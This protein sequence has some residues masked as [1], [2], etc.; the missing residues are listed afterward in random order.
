[1]ILI[2]RLSLCDPNHLSDELMFFFE[3]EHLLERQILEP[4]C[5][6][7]PPVRRL[8]VVGSDLSQCDPGPDALDR[9]HSRDRGRGGHHPIMA[10]VDRPDSQTI[11]TSPNVRNRSC[12]RAVCIEPNRALGREVTSAD[13]ILVGVGEIVDAEFAKS[14]GPGTVPLSPVRV[15]VGIAVN[16]V[17]AV[18]AD[19][20]DACKV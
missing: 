19:L 8:G 6:R 5:V 20:V 3:R 11:A 7:T 1:V 9:I 10:G 12:G 15:V 14:F 18:P 17:A 13:R 4:L 2:A 16:V